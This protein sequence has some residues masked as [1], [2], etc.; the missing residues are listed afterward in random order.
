M[1]AILIVCFAAITLMSIPLIIPPIHAEQIHYPIGEVA[2]L[3]GR[4]TLHKGKN[5]KPVKQGDPIYLGNII[6][7]HKDAKLLLLFIDDTRITLAENSELTVD[8]Y[9]FDPYDSEENH[10]K[11]SVMKGAF[12]W[13]SGMLSKRK[14]PDVTIRNS[15]GSI[16]IRGT[17]FWAGEI[18]KGYG[19]IVNDGLVQFS[20]T[21]GATNLPKGAST[22]ITK[23]NA[24][25]GQSFWTPERM[26]QIKQQMAFKMAEE[27]DKRLSH[28]SKKNIRKRHDYR[29]QMFP[30]K[31]NP[32]RPKIMEEKEEDFFSDEFQDI[33]KKQK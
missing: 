11:F 1:K 26:Y 2:F 10:G 25:E 22:F 30:Y 4:A 21:W 13:V 15:F 17:E 31:E 27:L 23:V 9:V 16:G 14:D 19:V 29:G 33:Q 18:Q 28:L 6:E 32:F 5:E 12:Y 3:E 20:G 24:I 7:T 8:E